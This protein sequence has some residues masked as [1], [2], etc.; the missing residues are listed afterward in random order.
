MKVRLFKQMIYLSEKKIEG[1]SETIFCE[2]ASV[3]KNIRIKVNLVD[4]NY[5]NKK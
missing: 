4:I 2:E 3:G 1:K 5:R